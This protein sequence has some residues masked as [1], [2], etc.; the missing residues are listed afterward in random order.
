MPKKIIFYDR[1]GPH[2]RLTLKKIITPIHKDRVLE[3]LVPNTIY[4]GEIICES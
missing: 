3:Y 4:T 2:G 1:I